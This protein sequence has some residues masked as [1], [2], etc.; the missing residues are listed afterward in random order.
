MRQLLRNKYHNLRYR[1][2]TRE[3]RAFYKVQAFDSSHDYRHLLKAILQ[4]ALLNVPYY[5]DRVSFEPAK[6][7]IENAHDV[8]ERFPF[9]SKQDIMENQNEFLNERFTKSQLQYVTSSGSTGE[10]IGLYRSSRELSI[11]RYFFDRLWGEVGFKRGKS[12]ILRIAGEGMAQEGV[13]PLQISENRLVVSPG[14][15]NSEWFAEISEAIQSFKPEYIHAYP[16]LL[17]D[18]ACYQADN[19]IRLKSLK[20]IFLASEHFLKTQEELFTSLYQVPI[21]AQY[22]MVEHT[23]FAYYVGFKGDYPTYRLVP[24]YGYTENLVNSD[25]RAQI[26]G[27]SYWQRAMPLI[28]YCTRD[29]GVVKNGVI[30]GLE[31]RSIEFLITNNGDRIP[32]LPVLYGWSRL[33]LTDPTWKQIDKL[34]IYQNKPG[35]LIHFLKLREGAGEEISQRMKLFQEDKWGHLFKIVVRIVDDIPRTASGKTVQIRVDV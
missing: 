4:E 21:I 23:N 18:L 28:R 22:G 6:I 16:S 17:Y 9:L 5:R 31:G 24:E 25:G 2:Q 11:Q 19:N 13:N 32:G 33:I 7:T 12:R 1:Q 29:F 14:H 15:L 35:E 20:G 26:V 34:Q 10:A 8:L 3:I 27:T 30:E